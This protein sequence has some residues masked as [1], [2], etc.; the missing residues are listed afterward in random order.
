MIPDGA[1]ALGRVSVLGGSGPAAVSR[2]RRYYP[3][4]VSNYPANSL[5]PEYRESAAEEDLGFFVALGGNLLESVQGLS[6][7]HLDDLGAA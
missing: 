3:P 7:I 5:D 4:F 6:K 2:R 1:V